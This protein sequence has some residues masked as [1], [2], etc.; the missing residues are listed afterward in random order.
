LVSTLS[1]AEPTPSS[2]RV[3][4]GQIAI[5]H[6]NAFFFAPLSSTVSISALP[7]RPFVG[8]SAQCRLFT[9][10][11]GF[12]HAVFSPLSYMSLFQERF[13]QGLDR[14]TDFPTTPLELHRVTFFL[15]LPWPP[16]PRASCNASPSD[17][18]HPCL[19]DQRHRPNTKH[20]LPHAAALNVSRELTF[21]RCGFSF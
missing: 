8:Y 17:N 9:S 15:L 1:S 6:D 20:P 19:F 13:E 7:V 21:F 2:M 10:P 16:I 5:A 3:L 4:T 12:E 18:P 14:Q 11:D